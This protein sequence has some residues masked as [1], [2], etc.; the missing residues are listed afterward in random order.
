[1]KSFVSFCDCLRFATFCALIIVLAGTS[2]AQS[3]SGNI[4]GIIYDA[5]GATLPGAS[6]SA[7]NTATGIATSTVSTSS[8]Q[9][10]VS[11]LPVGTYVLSVSASG[12][13]AAELTN[14]SVALNQTVTANVTMQ[15][16]KTSTRV[17]V[18]AAP[19]VIDTTTA[20]VQTTFEAKDS[21]DLA[22]AAGASGVINLSLLNAG[23]ASSGG[24]GYGNGPSV[25]GQRPT[26]NNFTVEGIDNNQ[27]STTGPIVTVPNDAVAEFTVLQNQFSPEFGHSSGGEF[28]QVVK[29][30]TNR[31][32]GS[33]YEYFENRN[34]NAA[35]NLNY[36][37]GD[38]LH[39]RFDSNRFGGTLGGP[40]RRNKMFFFANWE[41]NPI[42]QVLSTYY[43][44]PTD[45]AYST[46]AV[47][48]GINQTNLAE[49]RKYLGT[50]PA[51]S[52]PAAL[53][54]GGPVTVGPGNE[55]LGT[56][57]PAAVTVPVGQVAGMLPNWE[58]VDNGVASYDYNISE[59]DS[60]RA[61]YVFNRVGMLDY[62]G[63]PS[64][65]FD[66]RP[67]NSYLVTLSEYHTFS[68]SLIN[69]FRLGFNRYH[70]F[71]PVPSSQTFP[72]LD[73]FPNISIDELNIALGPNPNAPQFTIQNTYQ[74]A[75][76][77]NWTRGKH[78][79]KFGFDGWKS[80]SPSSFTQRARGDYEWSYLSDYLFDNYP[81]QIA[82][83]GLGNVVYYGDQFL[84]GFFGNDV[85]KIRPN[86]TLDL[87]LRYEYQT[88]PFSERSQVEN[89][90]ASVPG[91]I[92]FGVPQP[93]KTNFMPRVGVAYSPGTSGKTSIRTGFGINYDVL[94]DN[95]GSLSLPPQFQ[96]TVDVTGQDKAGFLAN[97]GI[98]PTASVGALTVEQA[99][100]QTQGFIPNQERP[101][102]IQ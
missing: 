60:L 21:E 32:H 77:V 43:Y 63:F 20:Q 69:E 40:I 79:F 23:V 58:N 26:N 9:Y 90:A 71:I 54:F 8:G 76:N 3:T 95:L 25:G 17:E 22:I 11:D 85:W 73:Q 31:F 74:L 36:V 51:A 24:V 81:D 41:Y 13:A 35:D 83:R 62:Q 68:P 7:R 52:S 12:F 91:L 55:S 48:P 80:I 70:D 72:G 46:L 5:S 29:S 37:S 101:E 10:R 65:F 102:S 18:S 66:V 86:L 2:T 98:L 33:L 100:L 49:L 94:Y 57:S 44:V 38:P 92:T 59:R 67:T 93:Q 47:M 34:L 88:V 78:S 89:V 61:R 50:A 28:N 82:Q 14:V 30:G 87:G 56:Q 39:P 84:L 97:G 1:M 99:R 75:D 64:V 4:A 42:G 19:P 6:V 53:P 16:E 96:T 45:A 15:V 27:K